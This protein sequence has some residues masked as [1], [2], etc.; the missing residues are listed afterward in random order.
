MQ[1]V[2]QRGSGNVPHECIP[3]SWHAG[4]SGTPNTLTN[5][6][7]NPS[8]LLHIFIYICYL[9]C[10]SY[11]TRHHLTQK[12]SPRSSNRAKHEEQ[13]KEAHKNNPSGEKQFTHMVILN[14]HT[15]LHLITHLFFFLILDGI[16]KSKRQGKESLH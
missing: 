4:P 15:S 7:E 12:P 5:F 3:R 16:H 13:R 8:R 2:S 11:I 6:P 9:V 1:C 10:F 14:G